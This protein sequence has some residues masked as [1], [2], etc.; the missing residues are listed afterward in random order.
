VRPTVGEICRCFEEE[1]PLEVLIVVLIGIVLFSQ[2]AKPDSPLVQKE[3][4][5]KHIIIC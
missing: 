4:I 3:L 1:D 5:L 2:E